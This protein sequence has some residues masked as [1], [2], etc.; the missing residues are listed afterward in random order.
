MRCCTRHPVS[1]TSWE[2]VAFW[3]ACVE[4]HGG[5]T[6]DMLAIEGLGA[7]ARSGS[8]GFRRRFRRRFRRG[9]GKLWLQSQVRFNRV[10]EKVPE[11]VPGSLGAKQV[12][13]NRVLE[14]GEAWVRSQVGFNRVP[15]MPGGPSSSAMHK[16]PPAARP[17]PLSLRLCLQTRSWI[18]LAMPTKRKSWWRRSYNNSSSKAPRILA[19]A[20]PNLGTRWRSSATAT[21]SSLRRVQQGSGEGSREGSRKPWCKAKSGSTGS[22]EGSGEGLGGFGQV[23]QGSGEG[24]GEGLGGFGLVQSQVRFNRPPE[25]VPEKVWEALVQSQVRPSRVPEKVPEK[26]LGGFGAEPR[27]V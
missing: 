13:F 17:R 7:R 11:K 22:R 3:F 24:S 26:V 1:L 25:K 8:T 12:R 15:D 16:Q 5:V 9:F 19:W 2:Q 10:L 20:P 18:W 27:E 23:Q 6:C 21:P 4:W 14:K